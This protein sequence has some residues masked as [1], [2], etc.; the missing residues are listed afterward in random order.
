MDNKVTIDGKDFLID[1]LNDTAKA[2]LVNLQVADRKIATLQQELSMIQ[3]ARRAYASV[4]A[5]NLPASADAQ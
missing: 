4:L 5:E 2:Q 3:T 1:S